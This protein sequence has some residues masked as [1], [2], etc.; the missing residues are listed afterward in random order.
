VEG[1]A[2]FGLSRFHSMEQKEFNAKARRH[3]DAK[4]I[5]YH[6]FHGWQTFHFY[7]RHP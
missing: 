6:G 2:A 5:L 4:K 7:P 3:K 1:Q